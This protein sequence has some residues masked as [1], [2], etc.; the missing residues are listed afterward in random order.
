[1]ATRY[2]LYATPTVISGGQLASPKSGLDNAETVQVLT[3]L[4]P[5]GHLEL[6]LLVGLDKTN[7]NISYI[8]RYHCSSI[9]PSS[10]YDP[11]IN[12]IVFRCPSGGKRVYLLITATD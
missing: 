5:S 11:P 9:P 12:M 10:T 4:D 3:K 7:D 1:M 8:E 6:L 2:L